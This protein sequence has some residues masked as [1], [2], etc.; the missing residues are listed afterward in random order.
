MHLSISDASW[1]RYSKA[2]LP[3]LEEASKKLSNHN[4]NVI[5]A[6]IDA[7]T[8]ENKVVQEIY[9]LT[10]FPT[11]FLFKKGVTEPVMEY[12]GERTPDKFIKWLKFHTQT[13]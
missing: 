11:I 12:N 1:C 9:G 3:N 2:W 4:S 7:S 8:D 10:G 6:R 13:M 5:L